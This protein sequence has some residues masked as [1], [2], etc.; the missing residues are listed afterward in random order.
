MKCQCQVFVIF[1]LDIPSHKNT[2]STFFNL[3]VP[4]KETT[5]SHHPWERRIKDQYSGKI[6]TAHNSVN[7]PYYPEKKEKPNDKDRV[8]FTVI[9]NRVTEEFIYCVNLVKGLY[10]YRKKQ[11]EPP[12]LR[13]VTSVE[14]PL[15]W[16][17]L[18][19]QYGGLAYCL[20]SQV[21]VLIN[22][23][24]LG[25]EKELK[26]LIDTKYTYHLVLDYCKESIKQFASYINGSNRPCAYMHI[27]INNKHIGTLIFMLYTDLAPYTCENFLRL[28]KVTKGGYSGTP[29]HRI[30]KDGW[31]QCGGFGLKDTKFYCENFIIPPD[32]RGVLCMAN[33]GRHVEC[34]TQ[35]FVLLQP[36][37]WMLHKYVAFGQLIDGESTLQ[38]IE[39][40]ETWYE[41]PLS[42]IEIYRTGILNLDC[43]DI[44]INRGAKEY[45]HSHIEDLIALGELL[46]EELMAK[47]F[48]EIERRETERELK[49]AEAAAAEEDKDELNVGD[50]HA[51]ERFM[52]KKPEDEKL[53][54]N[55]DQKSLKSTT[56]KGD[57]R[58]VEAQ[59]SGS[60]NNA[61][62]V[63]EYEPEE[64]SYQQVTPPGSASI[65]VKP[66]KPYYIELTDVPY[67]GEVSS[68]YDLKKFL[69]GDYCL[70]SDLEITDPE[71]YN[72]VVHKLITYPSEVF[73]V[74]LDSVDSSQSSLESDEEQEIQRYLKINTDRVSFAGT[75]I[76]NIARGDAKHNLFGSPRKSELVTDEELRRVRIASTDG[77]TRAES[78]AK[79]VRIHPEVMAPSPKVK[80]RPT[81]FVRTPPTPLTSEVEVKRHS[82]LTRLFEENPF[83]DE[84]LPTLKD[85]KARG[86]DGIP[87]NIMLTKSTHLGIVSEDQMDHY[88][89]GLMPAEKDSYEEILT[90]REPGTKGPRKM[91]S[92]LVKTLEHT[93]HPKESTLRSIEY[94]RFRPSLTV[95]EY[96]ARN[97]KYKEE[98]KNTA[99]N[100]AD[101]SES[102]LN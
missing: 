87:K 83:D 7:N 45:I 25:G 20:S 66:E 37:P 65:I 1:Y 89:R 46:I 47:V 76:R 61:F 79:K 55:A 34:S 69:K 63:S 4:L 24:I 40:V 71:K 6:K 95:S 38:K 43:Q 67:P 102:I 93:F 48:L 60:D 44:M 36:A 51:T 64:Y 99:K 101:I 2:M 19:L 72:A 73:H 17:D 28:C 54:K 9:G 86:S 31:I 85:Y 70:E 39:K 26:E 57:P 11:L 22:D 52:H 21:A 50:L 84:E 68:E 59:P 42:K 94:A 23:K 78:F 77:R 15:V 13:G 33:A 92:G 8:K 81:M 74:S 49:E 41:S 88:R 82:L 96:Q 30:V 62:D 32:R 56:A 97:Q 27:S 90:N 12:V 58:Q 10:T 35:F 16:N 14:W 29:I 80:R 18:K 5:V 100:D 3:R 91:S 98:L 75:I 53:D